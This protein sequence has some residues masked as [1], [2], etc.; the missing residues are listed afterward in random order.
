MDARGV[1]S[2]CPTRRNLAGENFGEAIP[3]HGFNLNALLYSAAGAGPHPTVLL[4][5]RLPSN[6]QNLDLAQSMRRAGWNVV[7]LH[8]RGSWGTPGT[9][10]FA[11]RLEDAAAALAWLSEGTWKDF[12]N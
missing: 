9:F 7:T 10:S 8:Y 2:G 12:M 6:E 3:S 4:L 11:N 5:H 1:V